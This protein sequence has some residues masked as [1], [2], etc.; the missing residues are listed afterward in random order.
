MG[1]AILWSAENPST[2]LPPPPHIYC[3][4]FIFFSFYIIHSDGCC[5][6]YHLEAPP[7]VVSMLMLKLGFVRVCRVP[8]ILDK[9]VGVHT[10]F[11]LSFRFIS[12]L[13]LVYLGAF[14]LIS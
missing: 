1:V 13:V 14:H 2:S 10:N 9:R 8:W 12:I 5:Y 6:G 4:T 7:V 11:P 3:R